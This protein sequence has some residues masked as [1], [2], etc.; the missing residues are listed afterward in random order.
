LF[1]GDDSPPV[2]YWSTQAGDCPGVV[3]VR[4]CWKARIAIKTGWF[5]LGSFQYRLEACRAAAYGRR[6]QDQGV[7]PLEIRRRIQELR[8]GSIPRA[9]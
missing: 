4:Q 6:L 1:Q 2:R 7:E 9:A 8:G 3:R 5:H